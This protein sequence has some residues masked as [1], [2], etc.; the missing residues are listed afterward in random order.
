[1]K[2]NANSIEK[3]IEVSRLRDAGP[4][5]STDAPEVAQYIE[6]LEALEQIQAPAPSF[7]KMMRGRNALLLAVETS[8]Q[9]RAGDGWWRRL[10]PAGLP[11]A[12]AGAALLVA[13]SVPAGATEL[14]TPRSMVNEVMSA[15]GLSES[16]PGETPNVSPGD[17]PASGRESQDNNGPSQGAEPPGQGGENPGQGAEPPGQ[18]GENPGQGVEPPGLRGDN[19]GQG[20]TPPGLGGDNPGQGVEPPGQGGENPGQ[21]AEPPGQGGENPG[22]GG[23]PPGQ[24]GENPGRGNGNAGPSG[25]PN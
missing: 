15:L 17:A 22:Q 8:R 18:G 3:L 6:T 13:V 2:K 14:V 25:P 19:P 10:A 11:A 23:T 12:L 9:K 7:S 24:G 16:K 21:G 5:V 20:G 1:M 4:A